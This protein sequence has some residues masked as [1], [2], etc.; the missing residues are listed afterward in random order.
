MSAEEKGNE[1]PK[2]PNINVQLVGLDG[3]AFS[4][5]GRAAKAMRKG[6]LPQEEVAAF[7]TEA[8]SGDYTNLLSTVMKW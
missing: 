4:I 3:N 7:M 6:K 5:L 1:G 2:Y 8:Q